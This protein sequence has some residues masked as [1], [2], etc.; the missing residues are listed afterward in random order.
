MSRNA[1]KELEEN[2]IDILASD[3][4]REHDVSSD[5]NIKIMQDPKN[6]DLSSISNNTNDN[7]I[8]FK[9][10]KVWNSVLSS[11]RNTD[12]ITEQEI[13]KEIKKQGI[14]EKNNVEKSQL[15]IRIISTLEANPVLKPWFHI[16][17]KDIILKNR[18][19]LI[20]E[21]N[22][23][24]M[25][26]NSAGEDRVNL[27]AL[28]G[29]SLKLLGLELE[30]MLKKAEE[31]FDLGIGEGFIGN[32]RYQYM[33]A[34]KVASRI[35]NEN[36]QEFFETITYASSDADK[37]ETKHLTEGI[38]NQE[39]K[40]RIKN[41]TT[42]SKTPIINN[43]NDIGINDV[44]NRLIPEEFLNTFNK[45]FE[46]EDTLTQII[47]MYLQNRIKISVKTGEF[48]IKRGK[49]KVGTYADGTSK[50]AYASTAPI[51]MYKKNIVHPEDLKRI[52]VKGKDGKIKKIRSNE[53]KSGD[54]IATPLV[55]NT[56]DFEKFLEIK[57][58]I[59][60]NLESFGRAVIK[61]SK[62]L[63]KE[64]QRLIEQTQNLDP[65]IQNQIS[66]IFKLYTNNSP[67][68][69]D[70][71]EFY[72]KKKGIDEVRLKETVDQM[73]DI[74]YFPTIYDSAIRKKHLSEALVTLPDQID[75][76]ITQLDAVDLKNQPKRRMLQLEIDEKTESLDAIKKIIDDFDD[77][78]IHHGQA[79]PIY[80]LNYL[81]NF[82]SI[83]HFIPIEESRL[84]NFVIRDYMN[85]TAETLYRNKVALSLLKLFI[86]NPKEVPQA[87]QYALNLFRTKYNSIDAEA[88][89]L[90][91]RFTDKIV[92]DVFNKAI[93][94]YN[95]TPEKLRRFLGNINKGYYA[96]LLI[97]PSDGLVNLS[98]HIQ[99]ITASGI[100]IVKDAM[101]EYNK[102]QEY[103]NKLAEKAGITSY[104]KFIEGY[105]SEE[106]RAYEIHSNKKVTK[107]MKA[108][109]KQLQIQL[110]SLR[111]KTLEKKEVNRRIKIL[112]T[113]LKGIKKT[114]PNGLSRTLTRASNYAIT[115]RAQTEKTDSRVMALLDQYKIIPSIQDTEQ[116]LRVISYI[117]GYQ[118][119]GKISSEY[120]DEQK[121]LLA[122]RYVNLVQFSLE[123]MAAGQGFG[124]V[125][126][127]F[128]NALK[129]WWQQKFASDLKITIQGINSRFRY[130]EILVNKKSK[131]IRF[132]KNTLAT[133]YSNIMTNKTNPMLWGLGTLTT[134]FAGA[135]FWAILGTVGMTAYGFKKT[136]MPTS[137][138][139]INERVD[140]Y[141]NPSKFAQEQF[142]GIY[143]VASTFFPLAIWGNF[144]TDPIFRSIKWM[145]GRSNMSKSSQGL[146]SPLYSTI[147]TS[148]ATLSFFVSQA[149]KNYYDEEENEEEIIKKMHNMIRLGTGV[150]GSD[151]SI[152]VM[153]A[154]GEALKALD[155]S[156]NIKGSIKNPYSNLSFFQGVGGLAKR[157]YETATGDKLFIDNR[158]ID[159]ISPLRIQQ[160]RKYK[161]NLK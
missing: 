119:A 77:D 109:I 151:A 28:R 140:S 116:I 12:V 45:Y 100:D 158:D 14:S 142:F 141:I 34:Q 69:Q 35:G 68:F 66:E 92:A 114:F 148:I 101:F 157:G 147:V 24:Y 107:E 4:N 25:E 118:K 146:V 102:N 78:G 51:L 156:E 20:L 135:P 86:E 111:E 112:K 103:W 110:K 138:Q 26:K 23:N 80:G 41:F 99:D 30:N 7:K 75:E 5:V 70:V 65:A 19:F 16:I 134:T 152:V 62:Q 85:T 11:T 123:P 44:I 76:L 67:E 31:G 38:P 73:G 64:H 161:E 122:R 10:S 113:T 40:D 115:H 81:K 87:K 96:N 88:T 79:D 9:I 56:L 18:E 43:I 27:F 52:E 106:L 55:M 15:L 17:A 90:G 159:Y 98:S 59:A 49:K 127:R 143:A 155:D 97:N 94:F 133:M 150:G 153:S 57:S 33:T 29:E 120:T 21:G 46:N 58:N 125:T 131:K 54:G 83:K 6:Q 37:L 160:Q 74:K 71:D 129:N 22:Q 50:F 13:L 47:Y 126:G 128:L 149:F 121:S 108:Q 132:L 39:K 124:N 82:K 63:S 72:V 36:F 105:I 154:L 117:I 130:D 84:D 8:I 145:L 48:F 60:Q 136:F 3:A 61:M 91:L 144:L 139:I 95:L 104:V 42:G 89:F 1:C 32:V 137:Q 53:L 2:V 93:P